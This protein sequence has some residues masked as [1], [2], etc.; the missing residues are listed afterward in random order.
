MY[1]HSNEEYCYDWVKDI[2]KDYT[3]ENLKKEP[4]NRKKKI[5]KKMD[6]KNIPWGKVR[7]ICFR[8]L[9]CLN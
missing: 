6:I 1:S 8:L 4:K 9:K 2:V 5:P 3:G 7:K